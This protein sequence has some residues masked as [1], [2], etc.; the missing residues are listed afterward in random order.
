[1]TLRTWTRAL[2]SMAASIAMA[3]ACAAAPKGVKATYAG[4]MNGMGIGVI[5]EV[6]EADGPGYRIVSE[7]K[8]IGLATLLQRQPLRFV[9]QGQVT[10][11]G[12]KPVHFE[13]R[14]TATEAPQITA[15][16]DWPQG[17]L[18]LRH[19]GR[20]E[21]HP[22]SSGTQDRLSI[23]YQFMYLP[24]ER[25]R[26]VDFAMTN[27]RKLDHYRYRVT[28]DVEIETPMGRLKTLHLVKERDPGDTVTEVWVSP[29]HHNLAV[30]MLIVE[31]DA[32][33]FEQILQ[34]VEFRD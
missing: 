22:V 20:V 6:F 28:P 27:G 5:T 18:T 24:L 12:L 30:K 34:H 3:G 33:R 9:S 4:T 17:Q 31:R 7:T 23:M 1:M 13:A 2:I 16:F 32:M 29:Q 21:S 15:D 11:E 10:R 25:T 14:R 26:S 8:P 19:N